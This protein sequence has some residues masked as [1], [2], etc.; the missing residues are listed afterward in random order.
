MFEFNTF[1]NVVLSL[2]AFTFLF[3]SILGALVVYAKHNSGNNRLFGIYAFSL[4]AWN[5][6][7]FMTITGIG[8][9]I[10]QLWWSRLAFSFYLL[11][12]NSFL[13]FTILYPE[14]R[15]LGRFTNIFFWFGTLVLFTLAASPFLVK[16]DIKIIEGAITGA[17]G[18]LIGFFTYYY[19]GI[20]LVS[21]S[22]L[23]GKLAFSRGAARVRLEYVLIGFSLFAIPMV[24]TNM[25]LPV[26][27]GN[28]MYNNLGPIFSFPML[29]VT[30]YA[31]VRHRL[32]DIRVIVQRAFFYLV[33]LG[34]ATVIYLLFSF[35][36]NRFFLVNQIVSPFIGGIVTVVILGFGYPF[37]K[38]LFQ[39][40]TDRL[41]F[42]SQYDKDILLSEV[43]RSIT[44][45]IDIDELSKKVFQSIT[46]AIHL[47]RAAFLIVEGKEIIDVKGIGYDSEE[48]KAMNLFA[49]FKQSNI[50]VYED[51]RP[52]KFKE[53]FRKNDIDIAIPIRVENKIVAILILGSKLS[54]DI[55]YKKDFDFLELFAN[56]AGIA[57]Q[58]A[59]SYSRIKQFSVELEKKVEERTW[60]LKES[61]QQEIAKAREVAKL[62]DEFV[63]LA[64]HELKAP[65]AA[66]RGFID[67]TKDSQAK[68]PKDAQENLA[69]IAEASDH[70]RHLVDDILEIARSE[71]GATLTNMKQEAFRPVLDE[72]LH[73]V[74]SLLQ[75]KHITLTVDQKNEKPVYCDKVK[76][77]EVLMNL[78]DNAI[79]YNR[80]N[81]TIHIGIYGEPQECEMICEIADTG[82]GIPK[83]Q[84]GKIFQKFFRA[85]SQDTNQVLG[86][87]LGL[88]ITRML[89]EK[90]SGTL[91]FSSIEHK[92]TTFSFTL[93]LCKSEEE[94][95]H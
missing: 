61:Q 41:F 86:T 13:Y 46:K 20:I 84:Q 70:L 34:V 5:L 88:F 66:I 36:L 43:T 58:N 56:E 53:L 14:E 57:I 52:G 16:G 72:V 65:V 12:L 39:R 1:T 22:I 89:I 24:L 33:S 2:Y 62:K 23:F 15:K 8:G 28:F 9:P 29:I 45:T 25:I 91:L 11:M 81:G 30:G 90:M 85:T 60:E 82:Y 18:P 83:D 17:L 79:K 68:F 76:L 93:P 35:V 92:G 59:K 51:M 94:G 74:A 21:F 4:A 75:E 44:S 32:L 3:N 31:I 67:L 69:A 37:Y 73:E 10:L 47:D 64:A 71:G 26:F 40:I 7:L 87:G 63:F 49:Q 78:I 6:S 48:I 38:A 54:G 50:L 55:F 19:V 80:E 42:R 27:F 95:V 77:K